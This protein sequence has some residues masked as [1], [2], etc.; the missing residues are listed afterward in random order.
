MTDEADTLISTLATD[1]E[2]VQIKLVLSMALVPQ[3]PAA[4][5]VIVSLECDPPWTTQFVD[6][7]H[8]IVMV[9]LHAMQNGDLIVVVPGLIHSMVATPL[10]AGRSSL[11][12]QIDQLMALDVETRYAPKK[13]ID[14]LTPN[15]LY[16]RPDLICPT[17]LSASLTI[18]DRVTSTQQ[19]DMTSF[20]EVL[21]VT[22]LGVNL[23]YNMAD[24]AG[25]SPFLTFHLGLAAVERAAT[26][27]MRQVILLHRAQA[28]A[29]YPPL[30]AKSPPA[31]VARVVAGP[32]INNLLLPHPKAQSL[33]KAPAF[34]LTA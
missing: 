18:V 27:A 7:D 14:A 4:M 5:D 12:S 28:M 20:L 10:R 26:H 17:A 9:A 23:I 25:P 22:V 24:Y 2:P 15:V 30:S 19:L 3:I 21:V 1:R 34:T 16:R 32:Q 13:M 31:L 29:S 6:Q 8:R 11:T 33:L